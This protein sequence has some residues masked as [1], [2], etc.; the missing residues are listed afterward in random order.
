MS[1]TSSANLTT[2]ATDQLHANDYNPNRM[3]DEEYAELVAEVRHLGR[4]PK[5]VVCRP[6]GGG[7]VIVDG[8]Q[9]WKAAQEVGLD[10]ITVEVI[11]ADDFEAMRQTYKRNRH[12]AHHPVLLGRMFRRMTETRGL[13][14]RALAEEIGV[15]EGTVRNNLLYAEAD[16]LRNCYAAG[17]GGPDRSVA[18]PEAATERSKQISGPPPRPEVVGLTVRQVRLYVKLPEVA[19][20]R[21]LGCGA[22]ISELEEAYRDHVDDDHLAGM[23]QADVEA[24]LFDGWGSPEYFGDELRHRR[25]WA[26]IPTEIAE[27]CKGLGPRVIARY[28]R[29]L[30]VYSDEDCGLDAHQ[31]K[32]ALRVMIGR[33][34]AQFVLTV[35]EVRE[36]VER[37]NAAREG[38]YDMFSRLRLA[39]SEKV[40]YLV[41]EDDSDDEVE[42]PSDIDAVEAKL[43]AMD[44]D[45]NAP[46]FIREANISAELKRALYDPQGSWGSREECTDRSKRLVIEKAEGDA[47][48]WPGGQIR[49]DDLELI[50]SR[51]AFVE[52][53]NSNTAALYAEHLAEKVHGEGEEKTK[54]L[55]EQLVAACSKHELAALAREELMDEILVALN[56]P[57]NVDSRQPKADTPDD[58]DEEVA[59]DDPPIVAEVKRLRRKKATRRRRIYR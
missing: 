48:L 22:S 29:A 37:T 42:P 13:S 43:G 50:D 39:V 56:D 49:S 16:D 14:Q 19:R 32:R 4:L 18:R 11:E 17:P 35:N 51:I 3:T 21:W 45:Q 30:Q 10:R 20:D 9:G 6:E 26:L 53:F 31:A 34:E 54:E 15:S 46:D 7:H 25:Q 28:M 59:G 24:G 41:A 57:T 12:G 44:L 36:V 1:T 38:F 33:D 40:G 27:S 52:E 47:A 55:T 23:V 5:P 58:E 8:E 2:L